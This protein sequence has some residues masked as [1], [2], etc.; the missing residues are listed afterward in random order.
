MVIESVSMNFLT[1]LQMTNP[2]WEVV[3]PSHRMTWVMTG[4]RTHTLTHYL[5]HHIHMCLCTGIG[6]ILLIACQ[7]FVLFASPGNARK[8]LGKFVPPRPLFSPF[9]ASKTYHLH[10]HLKDGVLNPRKKNKLW[11]WVEIKPWIYFIVGL[12]HQMLFIY[13]ENCQQKPF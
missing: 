12:F 2:G 3:C 1:N 8:Q 6:P 11:C 9:P 10:I 13:E 7:C 4:L 5:G